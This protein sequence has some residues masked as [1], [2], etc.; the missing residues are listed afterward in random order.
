[1]TACLAGPDAAASFGAEAVDLKTGLGAESC[2]GLATDG[3]ADLLAGFEDT[4]VADLIVVSLGPAFGLVG[5][6]F[7]GDLAADDFVALVAPDEERLV[8]NL[9][10]DLVPVDPGVALSGA[11]LRGVLADEAGV[12]L[13]A[14]EE[15]LDLVA[16]EVG[17]DL[18]AA[19]E[20]VVLVA[21]FKDGV[22]ANLGV[23]LVPADPGVDLAVTDLRG[24]LVDDGGVALVVLDESLD[25]VA[26]DGVDLVKGLEDEFLVDFGVDRVA[27]DTG[28][29]ME[30]LFE[31]VTAACL[32]VEPARVVFDVEAADFGFGVGVTGAMVG[33]GGN[34]VEAGVVGIFAPE[35]RRHFGADGFLVAAVAALDSLGSI[36]VGLPMED[37]IFELV[38]E[39]SMDSLANELLL[40]A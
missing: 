24:D 26:A 12:G 31:D 13:E 2:V 6:A 22:E 39:A 8:A 3:G 20:G 40:V 36:E 15:S 38:L 23:D 19:D 25:L 10:L 18:L 17:V 11:D 5:A 33:L 21:S 27:V 32:G 34:E 14:V 37:A 35:A 4:L 9:G 30:A 1:M 29:E 7:R 16:A 28:V